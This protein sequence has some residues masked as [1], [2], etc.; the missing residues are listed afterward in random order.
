MPDQAE[1]ARITEKYQG[2]PGVGLHVIEAA[3][4][5]ENAQIYGNET[6]IAAAERRLASYGHQTQSQLDDAAAKRREAARAEKAEK[7]AQSKDGDGDKG[8]ESREREVPEGR[9]TA[10]KQSTG[11]G[12]PRARA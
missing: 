9:T 11:G 10:P 12:R 6:R 8:D 1:H 3:N 7:A 4:E 5:L 2:Q